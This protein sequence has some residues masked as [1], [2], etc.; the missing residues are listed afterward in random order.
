MARSKKGRTASNSRNASAIKGKLVEMI[1]TGMHDA[2]DV[3][4][5]QNVRVPALRNPKRK[6]EIDV[7]VSGS[8]AGYPLRLAIEC[9]NYQS[10]IDIPKIDAYI[11]KLQDIGIPTQHG[12]YVT[13]RGFTTGAL[14]RAKEV[15]ITPLVLTGLTA[16][17]LSAEIQEAIQSVIYL[18]PEI[19]QLSITNNI[20]ET[21]N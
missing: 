5:E 6:R 8:F 15:G 9:K 20:E 4:V 7:L 13:A 2:P 3:T 14:D 17:R 18:L 16:D 19:T 10:I 12:I 1:V 11:G 21:N